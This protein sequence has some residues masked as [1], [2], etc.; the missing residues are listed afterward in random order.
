MK[1]FGSL[2]W[3]GSFVLASVAPSCAEVEVEVIGA[4]IFDGRRA[5]AGDV[6]ATVAIVDGDGVANCTGTLIAPRVVVTAAHCLATEDEDTGELTG[7]A[8]PGDQFIVAGPIDVSEASDDEYYDVMRVVVHE[9]YPNESDPV[10]VDTGAGRYDDIAILLLASPVDGLAVAR[11]PSIDE[12]LAAFETDTITIS[13]YGATSPDTDDSGILYIGEIGF[14]LRADAEIVLGGPGQADTCPGDSGGPAYVLSGSEALLVGATSRASENAQASCG[15]GGIY[16]FVPVYDA[17]IAANSEGLYES[18]ATPVD[19]NDP[20]DPDP[21]DP[22]TPTPMIRTTSSG[23]RATA[24]P[25]ATPLPGRWSRWASS[26]PTRSGRDGATRA[27]G[28]PSRSRRRATRQGTMPA[29]SA[30]QPKVAEAHERSSRQF[31]HSSTR[32]SKFELSSAASLQRSRHA[33]TL[34]ESSKQSA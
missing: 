28:A 9:G 29:H 33:P 32:W 2:G 14:T 5:G 15:D 11:I 4:P 27:R 13:G 23:K 3:L 16:A 6:Y 1:R 19:P 25:A 34:Y 26:R 24:A 12:A 31:S 10:D 21:D 22:T 20:N 17:W 30:A 8:E 7:I 18:D